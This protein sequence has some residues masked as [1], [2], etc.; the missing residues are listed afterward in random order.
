MTETAQQTSPPH[1]MPRMSGTSPEHNQG[2]TG[3]KPEQ[4]Q[5]SSQTTPNQADTLTGTSQRNRDDITPSPLTVSS[6]ISEHLVGDVE[7]NET[8]LPLNASVTLKQKK[9]MLYVPIDFSNGVT[10]DA[11]V[12]SGAYVSAIPEDEFERIKTYSRNNILKMGE[13]PAFQI[14]VAVAADKA[15]RVLWPNYT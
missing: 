14:Q 12:D 10:I 4:R 15:L 5:N 1:K 6:F 8:Y 9:K 11:L 3:I 7:S 13:P 2:K